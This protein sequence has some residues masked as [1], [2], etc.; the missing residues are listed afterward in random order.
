MQLL[1]KKQNGHN[2]FRDWKKE[3]PNQEEIMDGK[4]YDYFIKPMTEVKKRGKIRLY[5]YI[6]IYMR[7]R[8]REREREVTL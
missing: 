7:E 5:I 3:I 1:R 4:L 6:Y 8:E 2:A